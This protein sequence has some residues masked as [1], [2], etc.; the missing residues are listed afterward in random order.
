MTMIALDSHFGA[1]KFWPISIQSQAMITSFFNRLIIF[2]VAICWIM[3][4]LTNF[5]CHLVQVKIWI[6]TSAVRCF[7][8]EFRRLDV[9]ECCVRFAVEA[10]RVLVGGS[11]KDMTGLSTHFA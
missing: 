7:I 4:T 5:L 6:I 1:Y 10:S 2:T 3:L 8:L 11:E 9:V